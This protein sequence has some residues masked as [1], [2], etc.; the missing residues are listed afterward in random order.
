[1]CS[2][3]LIGDLKGP[4]LLPLFR[5][6]LV[7]RRLSGGWVSVREPNKKCEWNSQSQL[8]S[9]KAHGIRQTFHVYLYEKPVSRVVVGF[10]KK[11][12]NL[13]GSA[14]CLLSSVFSQ[15]I[16]AETSVTDGLGFC[17]RAGCCSLIYIF[18][19]G[20]SFTAPCHRTWM[21]EKA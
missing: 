6:N 17:Y 12:K 20:V 7:N 2:S 11:K 19:P 10:K 13:P 14:S 16:G 1:M 8:I 15:L 5:F 4:T 21:K 18:L 9:V 3:G